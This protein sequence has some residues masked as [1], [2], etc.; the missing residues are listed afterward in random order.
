MLVTKCCSLIENRYFGHHHCT[1]E[2][3]SHKL[4]NQN[5]RNIHVREQP[6]S[7]KLWNHTVSEIHVSCMTEAEGCTTVKCLDLRGP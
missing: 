6:I 5:N 1:Q 3:K 7:F 4:F 2:T